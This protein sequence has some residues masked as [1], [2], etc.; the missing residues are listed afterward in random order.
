M[1][2]ARDNQRARVYASEQAIGS[3]GARFLT[4]RDCQVFIDTITESPYWRWRN[5]VRRPTN[6]VYSVVALQG[7]GSNAYAFDR[8]TDH[9][10]RVRLPLWA[11]QQRTILHELAHVLVPPP[12]AGHGSVFAY[13]Y[14]R[15]VETFWA[16][17]PANALRSQFK[18]HQ[19]AV[20]APPS[21]DTYTYSG[22]AHTSPNTSPT[23]Y[24]DVAV[25]TPTLTLF[26]N[27]GY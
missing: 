22:V 3:N 10:A 18:A 27:R 9:V 15:L 25:S 1:S 14:I 12:H 11:Q 23:S 24:I 4:L 6:K 2:R 20:A 13:E 17:P 8:V 21:S 5:E 19:V 7:R 26:T 16:K